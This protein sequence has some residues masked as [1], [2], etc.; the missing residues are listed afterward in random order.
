MKENNRILICFFGIG[1]FCILAVSG[2]SYLI[3]VILRDANFA[4]NSK[5]ILNYW[6]TELITLLIF[7]IVSL[8]SINWI[9]KNSELIKNNINR[10]LFAFIGFYILFQLLQFLYTLYGTQIVMQNYIERFGNYSD[11]LKENPLYQTYGSLL[12]YL[13]YLIFGLLVY[14]KQK[15]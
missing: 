10:T 6:T 8:S 7:L 2:F 11:F 13:K 5:P 4:L 1:A 12:I 3:R 15:L 9:L 14:V